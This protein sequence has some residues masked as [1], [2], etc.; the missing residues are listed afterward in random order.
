MIQKSL[1][2]EVSSSGFILSRGRINYIQKYILYYSDLNILYK[3][4]S[5]LYS[6]NWEGT[7][8]IGILLLVI[9]I[10]HLINTGI[11]LTYI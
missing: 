5:L 4:S 6:P 3:K 2:G 1:S 8:I 7:K 9:S 10:N 11:R